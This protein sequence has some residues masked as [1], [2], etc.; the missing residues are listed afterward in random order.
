MSWNLKFF[1]LISNS[2]LL[3]R[4]KFYTTHTF[5]YNLLSGNKYTF[6]IHVSILVLQKKETRNCVCEFW[7]LEKCTV[8]NL[9]FYLQVELWGKAQNEENVSQG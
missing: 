5:I 3:W 2:K 1:Y 4:L 7:D 6:V 9:I 8:K